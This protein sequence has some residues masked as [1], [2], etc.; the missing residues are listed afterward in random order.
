MRLLLDENLP[1]DV[2]PLIPEILSALTTL[3]PRSVTRVGS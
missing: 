1:H 3:R 2:R